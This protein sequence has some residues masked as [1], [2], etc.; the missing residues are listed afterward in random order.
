MDSDR[1]AELDK[2]NSA[3]LQ[4]PRLLLKTNRFYPVISSPM[5]L[6]FCHLCSCWLNAWTNLKEICSDCSSSDR[7]CKLILWV[8]ARCIQASGTVW[9]ITFLP[10]D[11]QLGSMVFHRVGFSF[12]LNTSAPSCGTSK[13]V[14]LRPLCWLQ[15][16][17]IGRSG[18]SENLTFYLGDLIGVFFHHIDCTRGCQNPLAIR[19]KEVFFPH[20][21]EKTGMSFVGQTFSGNWR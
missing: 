11:W 7:K 13:L 9:E 3:H 18:S 17:R 19:R 2:A 12:Q 10:S 8:K 4:I 21:E 5:A 14:I 20:M 1:R 15:C 6:Y 16:I